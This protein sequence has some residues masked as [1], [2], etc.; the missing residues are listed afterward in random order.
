VAAENP[1]SD[2][3]ERI[4]LEPRDDGNWQARTEGD[5]VEGQSFRGFLS[6]DA[7]GEAEDGEPLYAVKL[8]GEDVEGQNFRI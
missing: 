6:I 4:V 7:A 1:K 8:D 2:K 3:I 5:D